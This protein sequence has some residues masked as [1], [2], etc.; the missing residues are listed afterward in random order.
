MGIYKQ[1]KDVIKSFRITEDL[2]QEIEDCPLSISEI[3]N[4]G[5]RYYN[6][7]FYTWNRTHK[8]SIYQLLNLAAI[9][10]GTK[11]SYTSSM[12]LHMVDGI[13]QDITN[14]QLKLNIESNLSNG[15]IYAYIQL[16]PEGY[17]KYGEFAKWYVK[18]NLG[19]E[20]YEEVPF[21]NQTKKDTNC[22]VTENSRNTSEY[23]AFKKEVLKR[24]E[25][26]Q[27]CGLDKKLE[28]H[29]INGYKDY[30][31]LRTD[32]NNGVTL[33]KYCHQKYHTIYGK[34]ENV[35]G[36]TFGEFMKNYGVR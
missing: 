23:N 3:F 6:T 18:V 1:T 21:I 19:T 33:C 16:E 27:C 34:Q 17:E 14:N 30:E 2:N 9:I 5:W 22:N 12:L 29:H 28:V 20:T 8:Y 26:C 32:V 10:D 36:A 4:L 7:N 11:Y 31:S 24:D 25:T 13:L 35:N 15:N